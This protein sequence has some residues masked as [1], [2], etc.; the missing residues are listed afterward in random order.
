[1]FACISSF[2]LEHSAKQKLAERQ[3][4]AHVHGLL[5]RRVQAPEAPLIWVGQHPRKPLKTY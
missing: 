1:M 2:L 4:Q 5:H 3:E